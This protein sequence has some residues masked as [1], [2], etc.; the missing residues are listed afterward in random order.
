MQLETNIVHQNLLW[1]AFYNWNYRIFLRRIYQIFPFGGIIGFE[2]AYLAWSFAVPNNLEYTHFCMMLLNEAER[3]HR[4]EGP[5]DSYIRG[6]GPNSCL[7]RDLS[8]LLVCFYDEF[9]LPSIFNSNN[10]WS[11]MFCIF[12][13]IALADKNLIK[14]LVFVVVGNYHRYSIR[15]PK[16]LET[17]I[18]PHCWTTK[19]LRIVWNSGSFVIVSSQTFFQ[20]IRR[21]KILEEGQKN[22]RI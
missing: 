19:T 7:L 17:P 18:Q 20:K 12:L 2:D 15:P 16:S 22:V 3:P 5:G 1:I 4:V 10:Y 6:N 8:G 9:F 13:D 14:G 21:L 11:S